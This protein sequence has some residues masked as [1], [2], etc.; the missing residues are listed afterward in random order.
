MLVFKN[1]FWE[2]LNAWPLRTTI[3]QWKN[4]LSLIMCTGL[5]DFVEL[6]ENQRRISKVFWQLT[7]RGWNPNE[8]TFIIMQYP[9]IDQYK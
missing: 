5:R 4:E 7:I 8:C 2:Y 9:G 1:S 3:I 6:S